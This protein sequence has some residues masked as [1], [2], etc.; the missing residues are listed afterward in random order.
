MK[1]V[2]STLSLSVVHKRTF[3][4]YSNESVC[5]HVEMINN[6]REPV[7][8]HSCEKS[9]ELWRNIIYCTETL[10]ILFFFL[11]MAPDAINI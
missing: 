3:N 5:F 6:E 9:C 7:T 1:I 2:L 11:G 4:L 8:W 10:S